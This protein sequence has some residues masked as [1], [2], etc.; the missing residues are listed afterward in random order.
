MVLHRHIKL[1][2]DFA[3]PVLTL[4]TGLMVIWLVF[5]ACNDRSGNYLELLGV[6]CCV[7]ATMTSLSAS[8]FQLL[9]KQ[10]GPVYLFNALDML[11]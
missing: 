4:R 5:C 8:T 6:L 9:C 2:A 3:T 11:L 1:D 10:Q 7:F